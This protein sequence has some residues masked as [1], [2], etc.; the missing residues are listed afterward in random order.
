MSNRSDER[1]TGGKSCNSYRPL[2]VSWNYSCP[3]F[4][5][6]YS[7]FNNGVNCLCPGD[8]SERSSFDRTL[9]TG[10]IKKWPT[11][12]PPLGWNK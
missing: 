4:D 11:G 8:I 6:N 12:N 10:N 2:S 3:K 5:V 1:G 9:I 7:T